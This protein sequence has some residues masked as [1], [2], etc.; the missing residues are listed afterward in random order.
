MTSVIRFMGFLTRFVGGGNLCV[1]GGPSSG[2]LMLPSE[3][4]RVNSILN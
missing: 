1:L 2:H 4:F 3:R